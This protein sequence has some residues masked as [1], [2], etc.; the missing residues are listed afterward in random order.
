MEKRTSM[1]VTAC[2][3]A[4]GE[5][6]GIPSYTSQVISQILSRLFHARGRGPVGPVPNP[7]P[8]QHAATRSRRESSSSSPPTARESSS[9]SPPTADGFGTGTPVPSPQSQSF[10]RGYGSILPTSLAYIVPSTRGCSPWRPDAVM[11]TTGRG[12]HSVLRIF[13]GRRGRTGHHATCGALPAAGP[14]LRLS[15]F[16]GGQAI[17]TDDRSARAHAP[18]FAATAAPS[19]SSGPGPCPDGRASAQLGT[20]TPLPVHPALQVLLTKNR[21]LGAL[22]SMAWL[23]KASTS[24]YLF[25]V[26]SHSNT[27]QKIRVGRRCN[28]QG[29]PTN[30]LPCT[31]RADAR[32]TQV[33]KKTKRRALPTTI[34]MMT[35]PRACQQPGLGP[36][37]QFASVHAPSRLADRLS[38][39]HIRPRHIAGPHPLPSRQ[40]QA[41]F[42]SLFKVLFIFPSRYLFA[43]GLSP[44]FS[45]GRNLPP[46]WGCI[47]KQPDSPT[48]PRGAT[49]SGHDGALTLSGAPFQGTWARSAA[50][51][52]SPDY[53]SDTEGDRF[54]WRPTDPHGS[55]S[56]KAGG[57][58]THDRSRALAQPPSITAPSTADSVFNQ[59]R[60]LGLMASGATCVQRLDGSRDSAIHTKYRISLRSSSMQ[61][62]RYPLPRVFRISVSQRR[63][64]EHRL[65]ADGGELN[66]FNF[67]GAFRAG[68]LLLGQEDTAEGSP[69]ETLLRLLLPLNDKVQWTSHNVA[70]SE[71]PTSPQSEHFTG[72][73]N[74]QIAPPTKNGHAPPPIESRKS[75]QSVNPYYVWTCNSAGGTTRPVKARSASPAEGTSRPVHTSGG[76]IDPTQAVSQAPSPES[77]PNSPSPV[78]TM[79]HIRPHLDFNRAK[80]PTTHL[81]MIGLAPLRVAAMPL[82]ASPSTTSFRAGPITL[83]ASERTPLP[84]LLPNPSP[85][86]KTGTSTSAGYVQLDAHIFPNDQPAPGHGR[87]GFDMED[88]SVKL[89]TTPWKNAP[90][91][92][93]QV[94]GALGG[95]PW[96][97]THPDPPRN[98][99]NIIPKHFPKLRPCNI[100]ASTSKDFPP[101]P[102]KD[103]GPATLEA[104]ARPTDARNYPTRH[105]VTKPAPRQEGLTHQEIRVGPRGTVEALDASPT[106]PTCPDDTK[107]KHQPAP[108]RVRPGFGMEDGSVEL[109][110]TPWKNAP[111]CLGQLAG[112]LGGSPMACHPDPPRPTRPQ[113]DG[114]PATLEASARPTDARNYPTRHRVT[115]PAP[116]QEGLTHQEIRV[117]PRGTVEALDASPTSPTCPDDTKPKHQPAPGRVR[118]GFGMEDGSVELPTT[119]WKNAPACLGQLAGALG[120][121][122]M[123]CHPDPPSVLAERGLC[124]YSPHRPYE[125]RVGNPRMVY[126]LARKKR[127]KASREARPPRGGHQRH[128]PLGGRGP[129]LLVGK[130]ATGTR[131]ASSPD[132]DLEAFS[133]NPTHV[134]SRLF[135]ARGRG[136]EGPVPNPSPDRHAATRSR[137]ESSSSSPPTADG[138]GTGT[139]VPS[140]Q[141]QS[142]SRGY[143]S[144]LPTS[145]AYI[146]PSTRG[147]SPWRPDAVMSTTGRGRHSV[148]RIFK[149]RRGRTGHH[150]TCGAL[151]A[152]GPYLRLSRFQGGQ[153]ICTDDRSARAHAPGFAA[154]AAPSYSSGPGPCPDGRVSAQLGTVT[155]LPVH[156]ASPVLLTKNGPLG[157]LDSVAWLNKAATPSYLFKSFA[158]IPKSDE[159]FARQYRCGPPPEFPLASPRSG[160][161]H[162]LSGPDRYALTRTLHRRS[163][164]VGG[165]THKGIPPISFLAPYGFTCPLTRTHVRLLG[166]CFKTGRMGSPQADARSTQVPKHTKRRAL[167]TT[168]AMMTS[169]RACQ[170]PGLGPPSQF[171]SVHA[172]SRLADRLSPFHIRPRHIAGPHPLPSRQFQALFDSLFKVLFIFPSRYLFAIGLSPVFSLGR[173]LPPDW[174][175]IPKQPDSPTA[176]RGATGSGHDGALTLSGAPFQGT[177]ARSAAEDA[178]PDYNSDTE[179]DRFSWWAFPG[180]LAVTKGILHVAKARGNDVQH[181]GR[182]ALGLMAS[183]ATCVQRL[184]GSRDSAI[185]T[186][187]RISLRSSSMQEPRYPLLRVFRISVSERRPH[188]HRLRAD[189]GE[190]NDFNFLG[191]FRAGVLLLGQEDTAEVLSR[192]FDARG[193]GPEGPVPNPSPDRHAATRSRRE[194]SSSSPPTADGFG[195]GTPVPSPQS[196]SFSR[197]YGSILPTSLAYIVPSTRGCSPWRPDAVMSTTGRGRHSVLRIF[198]GRRG[199]TGHHATCGALPAAGPYLRLSRFQGGQAI[200]TDDRSARAHAPG[201]A[202][203]AAPSY[204]SGPG[205]CPDG[206]VSAQLGTV[207]QLPV[208]PASPV[209]LTKNGPLGALDS[210]AWLNK[211]ATP[212]YLF[213]S[214]APIPKSDE[215]FARQYRCGPPP[216]FPLASPRS[217]IVHHLSG[218]DRYALTRTLH[219]RS[220]SVGGATHKGIPP[221][222]FLAPYGF[223]CPLTRTHVRL[224][225]PCFKTG[226]MGSP[227]A[228]ARSTQVPKHTKRRALPTTIAM[229]TSPRACQQPGLGPPSQFASVHAPSRLADRLS[230]FHIRPRHIAGPHPLPSRQFQALFDSLFK[231]L[232]IFPSRYLFAIGLSPVFSL[233]RNLPPDWGCIPKQPDSPTAPRGATGSGHDGAL[234]L[235]GAPFQGTWARSAAEDASPDYNS[236]TEGDRFSWRPTDPH[237]SKSRKAGGGDTHD[238][239]RALAQPPS[240]T[241]PSTADSVFNQPRALGLM[242]SGATCV[243][244]LDGSRD[245]A[246]HTKYRISLRSSSM[247]EPRYPLPRVFRIS[248]SQRRPHEHRLRADGGELNDFNFLGAFRAGVLL[249]GQEDTAEG[250]PTETLLRLLLPLNDKV[251][252]TSHNVAGSEPPTSP[253]SE[254]FT[255]PFNRQIAPPTKNGHAPPPIESRKSSQSVNP[256]Y[257]WTCGVLKATSADPWSASFM[258]ETRT[259]FVFHKSKNF[260]SDY[261]IRMP[262]T[263]PVN[264]YS[265]PEGQHNRIRIL[266]AGGTTRPVKARSASPAEGT[267]RPVHTNGGPIDPTQAVSQ[268]PSPESNPNSPSPVTTMCCHRKRLSKTDTT[269][270]CYSREPINR[271]DSTGQTHQPA[272]AACTASKGTLDTCDNASHHNSQLTLHTHH[273]RIL[274]RPQEGAWMERPTT[275]FRMIALEP[276][277]TSPST[278]SFRAGPVTVEASERPWDAATTDS[279]PWDQSSASTANTFPRDKPNRGTLLLASQRDAPRLQAR[280][281]AH[282]TLPD[283][284]TCAP[285]CCGYAPEGFTK[286]HILPCRTG[287]TRSLGTSVGCRYYRLRTVG[288]IQRL[289]SQRISEGQAYRVTLLLASQTTA[290]RLQARERAH[291]TLPDDWTCAPSCCGYAPEGFTKHHILPCRTG[292]NQKP[293]NARHYPTRHRVT[294]PEPR[295]PAPGHVRPG[296]G[297]EDDSVELPT[298]PWKNAPACLGQVA[299]ALGGSPMACHP[300]PPR[301]Q[302]D[303][304]PATLEASARP[305]DA[306]NYPTRHRVTKPAPRQEGLTHQEIR[307]GPRGTVEALDASPTSPTCPDDTKPK[308][309]PAPGRVRPGFG[310]EDGSVELPTTPWKNAPA[311][312]GQLA[313]ALGGSP[314]ACHPDPP[315]NA[316]NI[317]PKHFPKL[318]PRNI[319]ASPSNDFPPKCGTRPVLS[320]LFDA[321]GR[322]PEGPVPNPSPDRHAATRS[323]RESSSSSPPTA[324]GFGTGTPVPSPQSQSFS[325]GYGSILPTSL[326]YI[327]PSTR[328]CSPWRPDAVMS[329]TGRGRH[330]VLRIFKGRRGRTGHHATCGALP[331][332][333]PYLRLSRFQGGQAIC[334]DDRSARAHAPGFAATAA[335]SYSSGPG[336][337]PDG[338]VSAQLGTVTQLPVHPASPVLLT[339]NGPL[340]ALDS[341]AWLN[342]AATPSYLFKSF[343]PIPKSDERFA[344]QYR[345]G[346]PPEF[347]LA[348]P[349]S[350]IVH[351][352]SGPDRYALTRTLHRRS[353]SVGGATHKGIPPISF[354]APY[355][356]TCPL[357]RTHVRLLGPCF[358]TGR[359][360]SPQADARSTQ[361]P[362]HT[363]RRALPTTIAMMTSP[364]ACQQPG[365]GPPS[366]F[367][368]VH[369]PSRLADRLSPFHIRPRHIA[370]PHPLPSRQFQALFDSLFKVLFIFPSRY[371]FAIGL[372][373]VFSLGRNLPPDWGCIPKQ[374][375]SPT[376]PRGA[377]GSGHD[378]AL[379]L[380]GAPFQ[381]TWARSAAEDASPDYN[382]DTE[383]DRFSWRPTDPHGSKSRKAGGGDTHDR[384]RALAQP[385]SITAPSTADSVFNQP[386]ALGLMASGATC[387]QRLDG[388]RDS[389]IH[390]KYRISLRSSS[391][392]E[393]RYPLPRVFRIS[394]SQRRPH[395]HRLRADG[396]ELNDFNF[397][398][399]FRAGVLLLGQEDTAEGSPTETLLRLLLPLNDKVQWTSHNVAGSEPPTSPQSEHFTGPFNRQIAP[400]T[401]NG[402]APPPIES[403]KSSQS[404]NPYYVWTCGVLKAT[405]ADPWSASF[406]V[407]TRTLFVFHKSKNFTSD[408]EIRMPPTVP[409]NHYSDPE[410]QHNRIRIL[411]A[412]GTTRP[413]KA[414]SASPAEGTSRPVHTNGGPID[415]TQAVSQ[416]PSPESN[417]NSPSPVT[418]M[419]CHRKR[420][421]KTDTTAKC[422]SREPINRRD[423]TGQTHQPAFAAC[424]ASKGTLDTCDN[425]SHHN[426]QLTLHTHHFRI[427][428]RPQEGAWMERPT[429]HFRMIAL[430]PL[431]TSP[432]TTSFRAGPVTVEASERPWD[433][434]TTDSAPWDQSSASTAN[435]FP[436]DKPN[437]G[438]LLLA[439]QRDAPRLQARTRAHDTLPDDWTCAPSCC[440]YAPE[441]FTKHHIL[442]CRT[443]RTRSLGTS[444]GCRYYRLRTVGPIQRLNSQR[445]SEGQ[446]YRVTLLLASQTTAPRLQARERAHDTLPDDWTCAPSCCG[447]AP[448]GFT[449]HHILPCRTGQNQK[450]RN[451]RHYP[452]RH[453]VTKPEPRQPAPGHVRP[454]FGMEDD[455]VE[456]PTTPWKNAPACLG[457]VAGALGGSPMACHPDPPRPQK[458]GGPATLEAS[459]RPTDARNYPTRHRVTKPAPRQEGLTHQEIRVG[460]RGTVEA[461]DA[462][463]TSPTCPD[464]TKPKHQPAPGRVRPGFGMEDG[465]VELP[466]TPWK[467]APACLGQ[468][469]GALGGS[470]MACHPDPPRNAWNIIPKHFPKL[471]PR[472]IEASPSND[473]PPKCGTRP[474]LS[475]LFDARGRGPEGPVPNPSPDRH[476]ATRSRRESSSSSPPTADGFGTG[477]PVPSPQS[478]SFSR[479]YGSILPTSLAYIVPSTRGCSPWRPD[480]VMSTTGRG[481][482]SVLRIFKGRRG[483]TGHHATCGALPAAGPYLRLSR[484]QGGQAICTDDRSARAHAPGFAA[485]AAPSYSSGPGPC[486][487]GR[488]SA[489]LG[490][491]TQLPVHPASPVLLTKNGPL[492]ALD[493]VAWLNKAATPSYLF[494]SFAPIPKSDERFARQYRCGPPPEFPLASPRSGI[495]HHLSGPDRYAL[496]RTLH[497]RSGSVGGATHK[498]IPPISF[499]APYG[500]TCPLTRT[501]VRLLGPCFKTG[502]MGSPQADARS[503][504]VPKHT[505][506]RALPTT[507]AMMTSPRA[508]QQPGLGPPS[509]FASVHA[510]SRLADRLSPFH[511]RPRHIAGP[512]PLPSRQFQA[513]FDSLFKVLFIFPSRYLFAIGLS[514]VFSLGRNLPPDWGCI[515]KQPDSPTAPRGATGSGH[516]G[517]LTLSGAPFQG[518]WA[519]SAAEDASP[520]YNSDTEGDRFSWRP[521]DPHGS[522]S[523][524]AGGGDTHDRSRALAQPPSITAP[525]TADSVFNQPRA[526]GLMASGATCVQRLDGSRDSAI[527]TKYRISLRSSSMQE[528]RYPLPRVFRIS[529]SQRRPHEHRLRADG[530]ELND[531]NFLG[532]FRAGVLLL[533]QE[534]TAE[535]SPTETLLRLLLP[536]NDKVQWTSHNVAGSEPPTSPQSEHFTGPFNRQIAPPT[537]NG[538]AP[539]PIESRKSSQSVNPYY[540]WTCGVL[541]AT[542]ADPWSASFMVET[543]TLF[544]FHKSKNFTSDYEIRMPPTVPVNHY[545]DPE[546]QHN[547]IRILCAGGTTRPVKARSA[548]PAEGTSRP[549]HTNGGPIDPTQAVSQAPSPESNPNSPSPVTTMP[550][551]SHVRPGFGMEDDSVELPTT[552]WKNAPACLGQVAGALGG[553]PMACHPDPPR[554]Q[555]DG[556][557]ATLEASARPTDARNYPT[558]HRVTKPAPRQEGLTHQEIRVGPR[559]TVEALDASPTSPTCPDDTKPKHQPAPGRV[560]PGFGMEDGSVELPT[561][562]WKNAPACLGQV[563][564]ALG[565]SPMACHPDPPRPQKDGGP[566]TLEASA[567]PTDARNYPT[568]HCVTKPAPRQEGLMHKEIRVG[569]RGTIEALEASPWHAILTHQ[570]AWAGRQLPPYS[571]LM[572]K[573]PLCTTGH[574]F[575]WGDILGFFRLEVEFCPD[576]LHTNAWNI[577]PKHFP[578]LRPRNIEAS[579]SNDFPPKCGTRPGAMM[580][581]I[582]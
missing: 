169:P 513:L 200:C 243:Q 405:S 263:V 425:A 318:R 224:L 547:R 359:M 550:A 376:A 278:T 58:D 97:A 389:A 87:P 102:Q 390:T 310:M 269:A 205:P 523:R 324:D 236:D 543:R 428:Q 137:R 470:P 386:R 188:E 510:P 497:R 41:L 326:A 306:R 120:G 574:P 351:H 83:E 369:A 220:G 1:P 553:S 60:A 404:V 3:G 348:S 330:S 112:A 63:P 332:A 430:E 93:G 570:G 356:F 445:I 34:A 284:W 135:D 179:G 320:R 186:K 147:C 170:Q 414:R 567:R 30:Q 121:S 555:K 325:R 266:C 141:S 317:I 189:G 355:G 440:G 432:S 156:P 127:F 159:R 98:A 580:G 303:G 444:V 267:S 103:G 542:S 294:K 392:Q 509:Q 40:F 160:I 532:A 528:P 455:S 212:S 153:A 14:Y 429:T 273:F 164:S 298:T 424:T 552:P 395:E 571:R 226:R 265:D 5:S 321:R 184:D 529:V 568:R 165:A 569:P 394:V 434:A 413:V 314:M 339:K 316:W 446:A 371:L 7:S 329:T 541:K 116:R 381:G 309:Q 477:T 72:P 576:F 375:D 246:I 572:C 340:G 364:R 333:G 71:P 124:T 166:P 468:L 187:Y 540:V 484:F 8:E 122:P 280:T 562:P 19:Y 491:V 331:A 85:S 433:A 435:T 502:R 504:Q 117:G 77:N 361:V 449:K 525:S 29:D 514:P 74:R 505:K 507:I 462:S 167:P 211:A 447:Y 18:G 503:T 561:T 285:S 489:Q 276:L 275:H 59:P 109:P 240:I 296:F 81:R 366:Q 126:D 209:L 128:V 144:I 357:T 384:S 416:A 281:R 289:N 247:Q 217:G 22:D 300:D 388:S 411:C 221:I 495:V 438:T 291:D 293:R 441:G 10:S 76:P 11:S 426:S 548:S 539:P 365:L 36:P 235:S 107:P 304:G 531:F 46:D 113:K 308:H 292:Q 396:G 417:P 579:P 254:H 268:A 16:Q 485:T 80:Q 463:P 335:P 133:H 533:G 372:S 210:V 488:V 206:R 180:S 398:G 343:A 422:Y 290:P 443:G 139:P 218:P 403:R 161:V 252:W 271:R 431:R 79:R 474:V 349:R 89:P 264:H 368:S 490:T 174:G 301:P 380:S 536:L 202:A 99:W 150:A 6:H 78:T 442:P 86:H 374:P 323:R 176:P 155:Q 233:G 50:E 232:F 28:P 475:R 344:R 106:S 213:K 49:G 512:H 557:P 256:Y 130:R 43:I 198:K 231:V 219:R 163:G 517:A 412:G 465:S 33:P 377:T 383:G 196:Q 12:R 4:G 203:T 248:V 573:N 222:S 238:R 472:N 419:C 549:V 131:I 241:A 138:F 302:K 158:P 274:Q 152:A 237:G 115:K 519:R 92:L 65:R 560:R 258:V 230:P 565:G 171:A 118:P 480:A 479:G 51:D 75:S 191:A 551:P 582:A 407:E 244:R 208:H 216:E 538:H 336:P 95:A 297:M 91:C 476:A 193:R 44:V 508:C 168:I 466:T 47:P 287:R 482:H 282:D 454:G 496:T 566:A 101:K 149:G 382:S 487:D 409:V 498:G 448:E 459:A 140:P 342:K 104:S 255:G 251:Q 23:N 283:D 53:N 305:T 530:G 521:T 70:G 506:R 215:R 408:Y 67:L 527:H 214:F 204:S 228:D 558:R 82:K 461:L 559:G 195:T 69:T 173:N 105:R 48:A 123:A 399:A 245:S 111:A 38:P 313:G 37:S 175:C 437:R 554:P 197:G 483:R 13:K 277:R 25:K 397:L 185:H 420:L 183:G 257:V 453:R 27:S 312:L 452:T 35:S 501:H 410:G 239:S 478:Q 288:P 385:P 154:T 418:T 467:N 378:G 55:K 9:S 119:P 45:L 345:C 250:S 337:C 370:G 338:R 272:F 500:F 194:S 73:F 341:V 279:A 259:L 511:I 114:G 537:K 68:V 143:G 518:T 406:M 499:L 456:L 458:D 362:K 346:P 471:R 520:D 260:T 544:V 234:T 286:H 578:K 577:I 134:L 524:K 229:M 207:T 32:S 319:E 54:S 52:A 17:C 393:P 481:R 110:T 56:R 492:G 2:W 360:G 20:V 311:C 225:G 21:P 151:P 581:N 295:Q 66:D 182:R 172:P 178:S 177:W 157:A 39:F 100:E 24:S 494:K 522:K 334:T 352:L 460:P 270:K 556:G 148:L 26:C 15:R 415:P 328:G 315:R 353:G 181:P 473:F 469:A 262:P 546:G 136:P 450:P 190:L 516:D 90:A 299:G 223:T 132:S 391:M 84:N 354:L 358:K 402:H 563:A 31:L 57:G 249:L 421:S 439:S 162:H 493:S 379:T 526:L 387:V 42:D 307:V 261:E 350:G 242:A 451:A 108:G 367:A 94:A 373:P 61:E 535:G 227:Q 142:F 199:R 347:P 515:P 427:L 201:F 253:Q 564:G 575:L 423:S 145:L 436:R 534:D 64:H 322:G 146:V 62:P 400:P 486:P 88:D 125:V 96:H 192:L 327:V 363:K 129:L 401:K 457:Q 545:S 464:D